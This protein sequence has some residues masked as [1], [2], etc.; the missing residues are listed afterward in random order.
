MPELD[1]LTKKPFVR[2]LL[3]VYM[4]T[5]CDKMQTGATVLYHDGYVSYRKC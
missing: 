2:F 4:T 5:G 1:P 3:R